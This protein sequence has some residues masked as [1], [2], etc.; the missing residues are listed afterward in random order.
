MP[1]FTLTIFRT[2]NLLGSDT[3]S[4]SFDDPSASYYVVI[5]LTGVSPAYYDGTTIQPGQDIVVFVNSSVDFTAGL[6]TTNPRVSGINYP[7]LVLFP[8]QQT[9]MCTIREPVPT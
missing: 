2:G 3:G 6:T 7:R 9:A 1:T 4:T 8:V 5:T